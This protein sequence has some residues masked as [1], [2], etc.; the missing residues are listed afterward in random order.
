MPEIKH[1]N[2]QRDGKADF[3]D[4]TKLQT[5]LSWFE[6]IQKSWQERRFL[7]K[8]WPQQSEARLRTHRE[9]VSLPEGESNEYRQAELLKEAEELLASF[10]K[11]D[12]MLRGEENATKSAANDAHEDLV[13]VYLS[14]DI[15]LSDAHLPSVLDKTVSAGVPANIIANKSNNK[16]QNFA[17]ASLGSTSKITA[18][19]CSG[20][21]SALTRDSGTSAD[22]KTEYEFKESGRNPFTD[23]E[24]F[25]TSKLQESNVGTGHAEVLQ[26]EDTGLQDVEAEAVSVSAYRLSGNEL[27]PAKVHENFNAEAQRN[28]E[29][30]LSTAAVPVS[31]NAKVI[32]VENTTADEQATSTG[33][34]PVVLGDRRSETS[35]YNKPEFPEVSDVE[36]LAMPRALADLRSRLGLEIFSFN[37]KNDENTQTENVPNKLL[38]IDPNTLTA[39][40]MKALLANIYVI[41][42]E[43]PS[44]TGKST[45]A[46]QVAFLSKCNYIID[47]GLLIKENRIVAGSSAKRAQTKIESV[48]Q[49]IFFDNIRANV[50]RRALAAHLP[51]RLLILG[52]SESMINKIC[53]ALWLKPPAEWIRISDVATSAEMK[54][55]RYSRLHTGQ[56]AIPVPMMELK[57]E[58]SGSIFEP[59]ERLR[60][61]FINREADKDSGEVSNYSEPAAYA[62]TANSS[63]PFSVQQSIV[64]PSFSVLGHYSITDQALNNIVAFALRE[65]E[66]VARLCDCKVK[67]ETSGLV[68]EV[69]VAL[70]YGY[71]AQTALS[72]IQQT[73][74]KTV[75]ELTAMNVLQVSVA[76]KTLVYRES[77]N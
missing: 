44:G 64:R 23:N 54:Q 56:H 66:A 7:S 49:A 17:V 4:K 10:D 30:S 48:R 3:V 11:V 14:A 73:I 37:N 61:H 43:G 63:I 55:A 34:K 42:F 71:N 50:M 24:E 31:V 12:D 1:N 41:A 57:H 9:H 77:M 25:K 76:A 65:L 52:T 74:M 18:V 35:S 58:F 62:F 13:A 20:K 32:T 38:N 45:R 5:V 40:E 26:A 72:S 68:F 6:R 67:Q 59:W 21:G 15:T 36:T 51:Q 69:N 47:D 2:N 27:K 39:E 70:Y 29:I 8:P 22:L 16:L 53:K 75:A 60:R 28:S 46:S 19:A 33:E